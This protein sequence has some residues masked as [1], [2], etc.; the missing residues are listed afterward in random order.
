M[1][2][3][4]ASGKSGYVVLGEGA[5]S[6]EH[7][8]FFTP[9]IENLDVG[10]EFRG[11]AT[12]GVNYCNIYGVRK[13]LPITKDILYDYSLGCKLDVDFSFNI[14]ELTANSRNNLIFGFA[15]GGTIANNH[16][17]NMIMTYGTTEFNID[18]TLKFKNGTSML[19]DGTRTMI[20]VDGDKLQ[21]LNEVGA[22][23]IAELSVNQ[24]LFNTYFRVANQNYTTIAPSA[25]GA[26]VLPATPAGYWAVK[27]NG[28]D[29]QIPYY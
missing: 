26:G 3:S 20:K 24:S 22:V 27:I 6:S 21:I 17:S 16:T 13:V 29:R 14:I 10:I 7:V 12:A 2:G 9:T 8:N 23:V 4:C 19:D 18:K 5:S 28:T 25:G 15:S 1:G 11:S